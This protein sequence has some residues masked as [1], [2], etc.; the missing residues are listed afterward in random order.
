MRYVLSLPWRLRSFFILDLSVQQTMRRTTC[1]TS[2]P[3]FKSSLSALFS[4][5]HTSFEREPRTTVLAAASAE[6]TA[7]TDTDPLSTSK[8]PLCFLFKMP[9]LPPIKRRHRSQILPQWHRNPSQTRLHPRITSS[10]PFHN[11]PNMHHS[12]FT[13]TTFRLRPRT[14]HCYI[15]PRPSRPV[16]KHISVALLFTWL[17]WVARARCRS[18]HNRKG[19]G[20]RCYHRVS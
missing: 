20:G 19:N 6:I 15:P 17:V 18:M 1:I 11:L 4:C 5:R 8:P 12:L 3:L 7:D 9:P 14:S 10:H 2:H 16:R 13:S